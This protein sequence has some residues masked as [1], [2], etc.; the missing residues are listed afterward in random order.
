MLGTEPQSSVTATVLLTGEPSLQHLRKFKALRIRTGPC[1]KDNHFYKDAL[2]NRLDMFKS[3]HMWE[4]AK[5]ESFLHTHQHLPASAAP[6]VDST[7]QSQ[8]TVLSVMLK[9]CP[10]SWVQQSGGVNRIYKGNHTKERGLLQKAAR[11]F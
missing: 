10:R 8:P 1:T 3:M 9:L 6:S 11:D 4:Q 5:S 7:E 2:P